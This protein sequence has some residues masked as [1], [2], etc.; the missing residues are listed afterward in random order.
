MPDE[1]YIYVTEVAC[2]TWDDYRM[3]KETRVS[4]HPVEGAIKYIREKKGMGDVTD[5]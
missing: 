2:G 5:A 4:K 3:V 1:I